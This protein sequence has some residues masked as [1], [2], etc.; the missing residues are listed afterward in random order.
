MASRASRAD[1]AFSTRQLFEHQ[2]V[3][4][5]SQV[6]GEVSSLAADMRLSEGVM[7]LLPIHRW[8]FNQT[9]TD[10]HHYNQSVLLSVPSDLRYDMLVT[11]LSGLAERHG[12]LRL[13]FEEA[14]GEGGA[15]Y[16]SELPEPVASLCA[17]ED[18]RG[19]PSASLEAAISGRCEEAQT[20]LSPSEGRLFRSVYFDTDSGPQVLLVIL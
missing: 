16:Q 8:F 5:L 15:A 14:D 2:T 19:M 17:Y 13:R 20:G 7:P 3:R 10:L 4:R 6:L 12:A 18:Y 11:L 9:A 1:I